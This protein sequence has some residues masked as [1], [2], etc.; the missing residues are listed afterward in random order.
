M[1]LVL[2]AAAFAEK[3]HR[4]MLRKYVDS[5][6]IEH[7]LAVGRIVAEYSD[8]EK[9]IA[10]AILHDVIEDCGVEPVELAALF[11]PEVARLVVWLSK[12]EYAGASRE[13][14]ERAEAIR[15]RDAPPEV[16]LIKAADIWDNCKN[17]RELDPKWGPKYLKYRK[18]L[19]S[20]LSGA[21]MGLRLRIE[22]IPE[23]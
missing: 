8:D 4:G 15:Y 6:Y 2:K 23:K 21:P 1:K 20:V 11:G 22:D 7:P 19:A 10:A 14:V 16:H 5:P 12:P 18:A 17:I 3:A 9:V 13:E